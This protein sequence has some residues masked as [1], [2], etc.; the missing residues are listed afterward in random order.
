V[1]LQSHLAKLF[2][3]GLGKIIEAK[4]KLIRCNYGEFIQQQVIGPITWPFFDLL[5]I[6]QGQVEITI[7]EKTKFTLARGEALLIYPN[8]YFSGRVLS[9]TSLASVQHFSFTPSGNHVD[10]PYLDSF[11][12]LSNGAKF[13]LI[14]S[15]TLADIE[16][17]LAYNQTMLPA[18]FIDQMQV[19]LLHL[20]LGQLSHQKSVALLESKYKTSLNSLVDSF[21]SAPE[22]PIKIENMAA[23]INLSPSHF[24]A[25]FFKH[26]GEPPQRY[27]LRLRMKAACQLL[28]Q[29]QIPIKSISINLGYEDISYFYRHFK[30]IVKTTPLLYRKQKLVIG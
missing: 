13:Y 24:R 1:Q 30:K 25:E 4:M 19:N 9:E 10:L 27:L 15:S 8:T 17:S 16:R 28:E 20:I 29:G 14:D 26:Y 3:S 11:R 22:Q 2:A 7:K 18:D 5:V 21:A 23:K 12:K 6:H